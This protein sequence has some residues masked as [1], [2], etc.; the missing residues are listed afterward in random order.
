MNEDKEEG[1]LPVGLKIGEC[2][3]QDVMTNSNWMSF[4]SHRLEKSV[5]LLGPTNITILLSRLQF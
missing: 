2:E 1:I 3:V 5:Q 4:D